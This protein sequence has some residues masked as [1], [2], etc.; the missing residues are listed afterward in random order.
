MRL[1]AGATRFF[2]G[3]GVI[4][5]TALEVKAMLKSATVAGLNSS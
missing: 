5:V 1:V 3:F 4:W 2:T